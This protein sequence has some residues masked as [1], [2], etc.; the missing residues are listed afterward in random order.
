MNL[1]NDLPFDKLYLEQSATPILSNV[2]VSKSEVVKSNTQPSRLNNFFL[3]AD[4]QK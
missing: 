3:L 2:K 4:L 1:F